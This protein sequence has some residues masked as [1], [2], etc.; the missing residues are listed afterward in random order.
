MIDH[1][2]GKISEKKQFGLFFTL[3]Y[4]FQKIWKENNR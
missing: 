3:K 2:W 1:E 4:L